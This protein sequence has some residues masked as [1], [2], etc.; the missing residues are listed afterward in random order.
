VS[1]HAFV[2]NLD[3]GIEPHPKHK[4]V[5]CGIEQEHHPTPRAV[6]PGALNIE[7]EHFQCDFY[8]QHDGWAHNSRAAQA[9]WQ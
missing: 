1:D 8:V 9:I 5:T 2:N 7:G 3:D 4:C 6:C